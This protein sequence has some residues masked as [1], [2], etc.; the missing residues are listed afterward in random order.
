M[1][2]LY[3]LIV[4]LLFGL[5]VADLVVGVSNDAVNFLNSAI[6]SRVASRRNIMIVA[7]LGILIGATFSG[8]MMEVARKGIFN[9]EFYFFADIMALFLA[10]MLTDIILL[11]LF[12]TFGM[13]TSTTVSIVFELLGAAVMIAVIKSLGNGEGLG[14]VGEYINSSGALTIISGIFLSVAIAFTIGA[15][16][17]YLSRLLFTFHYER[18]LNWL[19][20]LWSGLAMAAMTY[21]L[22]IKGLKGAS[23]L[24]EA[25]TGWMQQN[26]WLLLGAA[27][28]FWSVV[29]Q[30]MLAIFRINILRFIVLFGTF[31]LAMA[32]AGNDLVNFIGVPVAGF[33]SYNAWQASGEAAERY[34][35]GVLGTAYPTKTYLLLG[36]GIIMTLTLWFSKKARSVT[37]TEVNLGRQHEGIERFSPNW[38]ARV[39]VRGVR[40]AGTGVRR[41]LP[42]AWLDKAETSFQPLDSPAGNGQVADRPAFDLV[43]AAVNLTVASALIALAT[44]YKLPLST[45]YVS[46]MVAMGTSLAD[47]AWGRD[48]AV[49]RVAGVLNVIGGWFATAIIAFTV[50]GLFALLIHRFGLPAIIG[51]V[52][53]AIVF[54][55]RTF[56]LHR[57]KEKK[58]EAR[59]KTQRETYAIS[60]A[61]FIQESAGHV[62]MLLS[63]IREAFRNA[64]DGLRREDLP[65]LRRLEDTLENIRQ[66]NQEFKY[67]FYGDLRRMN[68]ENG[69]SS[70]AYLLAYDLEQDILQSIDFITDACH[71][72]VENSLSPLTA[73]QDQQLAAVQAELQPYLERIADML[74]RRDFSGY[75]SM[76][77]QKQALHVLLEQLLAQQVEGIK[78]SAYGA[79]N[80]LLYFSLLL[81]TK[82]LIAVAAR[83]A[84]LYYRIHHYAPEAPISL[85]AGE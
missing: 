20:V 73:D 75:Q 58:K 67:K 64:L 21:F 12:N 30:A 74:R 42:A 80:S 69:R 5:A 16:V 26:T 39:I 33:E 81:E 46:F 76:L 14:A 79:R 40:G 23:F 63:T 62:A 31:S 4:F 37:E 57:Q 45:T 52:V 85:V 29:M 50:S 84:K 35:M 27:F 71:K 72:H 36:A 66:Q 19:G 82:D 83:F 60:S 54:I 43:R 28:V 56:T 24:P 49:Y 38:L 53:L 10:V 11:D 44:S 47:R 78:K 13:P 70:R 7:G 9:P 1:P 17:M 61:H 48:S 8:G 65:L 55:Y 32:F 77:D 18:L 2:D 6:G 59:E 68:E 25:V 3:L 22:I 34:S 51:L 15:V 41:L